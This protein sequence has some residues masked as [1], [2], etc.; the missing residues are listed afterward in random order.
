MRIAVLCW[1][2]VMTLSAAKVVF[3]P[4]QQHF[5]ETHPVLNVGIDLAWSG[6]DAV[7]ITGEHTGISED[8]LK[9]I[10]KVTGMTLRYKTT[11]NPNELLELIQK[12][13]IDLLPAVF[14]TEQRAQYMLYT[15]PYISIPFYI[16][17][18]DDDPHYGTL[19]KLNGHKVAVP[20]GYM[21]EP[22]LKKHYPGIHAVEAYS[23]YDGLETVYKNEA[24]AFINDYPSTQYVLDRSFLPD[25]GVNAP[26]A[27]LSHVPVYMAVRDDMGTLRDIINEVN[28]QMSE[29]D[30]ELIRKRWFSKSKI[31]MLNF[32]KKERQ[33]IDKN[34]EITFSCDPNWLPFE[35]YDKATMQFFGIANDV[36]E[37]I[38]KRTGIKFRTKIA[39]DWNDAKAMAQKGQ[40]QMLPAATPTQELEA[41]M[42]FSRPY[43]SVPYV[44][45]GK[46]TEQAVASLKALAGKRIAIVKGTKVYNELTKKYPSVTFLPLQDRNLLIGALEE[47]KA[48]YFIDNLASASYALNTGEYNGITGLLELDYFYEPRIALDKSL[49]SD[50]I[51]VL[52]KAIDSITEEEME[53]AYNKWI[54]VE[55]LDTAI[56]FEENYLIEA[57]M[58]GCLVLF[59]G[60]YWRFIYLKRKA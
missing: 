39:K 53:N 49:G 3:T 12:K 30:V 60:L 36:L 1:L 35:G 18:R 38:S 21:I 50:G 40:T 27:Q 14:Y 8:Y 23:I 6:F 59:G 7:D 31:V 41:Y 24:S 52:N 16:F 57:V 20:R 44:L 22:W 4:E 42:V 2:L 25:M 33:W 29:Q 10:S 46:S 26:V 15:E 56:A 47:G 28:A 13:E 45:F 17:S 34:Q 5:I 48:D 54:F 55:K 43:I 11:T 51:A 32:S 9:L 58:F 37:L 19:E